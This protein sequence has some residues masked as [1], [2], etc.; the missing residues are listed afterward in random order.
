MF[1]QGKC[2]EVSPLAFNYTQN[3]FNKLVEKNPR[4]TTDLLPHIKYIAIQTACALTFGYEIDQEKL[5][6]IVAGVN[7]RH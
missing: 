6:H 4:T 2:G 5:K 1:D 3:Y 7:N